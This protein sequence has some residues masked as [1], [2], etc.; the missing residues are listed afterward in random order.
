MITQGAVAA[1][2]RYPPASHDS[3]LVTPG[4]SFGDPCALQGDAPQA[5]LLLALAAGSAYAIRM[6]YTH[7]AAPPQPNATEPRVKS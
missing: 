6:Q 4:L 2:S 7:S 3:P 5:P 1:S